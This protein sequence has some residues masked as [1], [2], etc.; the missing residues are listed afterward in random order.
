MERG[1]GG[2]GSNLHVLSRALGYDGVEARGE[3]GDVLTGEGDG[4]GLEEG[5]GEGG[6]GDGEL[7]RGH[8]GRPRCGSAG[9]AS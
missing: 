4:V 2:S 5:G 1:G 3:L 7:G 9:T 8:G 6:P